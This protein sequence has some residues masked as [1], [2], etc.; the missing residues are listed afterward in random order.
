MKARFT[1]SGMAA[2]GTKTRRSL[3]YSAISRPS[4]ACTLVTVGGAL[5]VALDELVVECFFPAD[6][7]TERLVL[8]AGG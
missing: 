7:E 1:R 6:A 5:E 8:E 2:T 3:A 4:P